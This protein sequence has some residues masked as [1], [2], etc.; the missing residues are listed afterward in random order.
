M[1][2]PIEDEDWEVPT[3]QAVEFGLGLSE[4]FLAGKA[5]R[6]AWTHATRAEAAYQELQDRK[7]KGAGQFGAE[8][9]LSSER[10]M[11]LMWSAVAGA[12]QR[13]EM[14]RAD[15]ERDAKPMPT[16][17][18]WKDLVAPVPQPEDRSGPSE[19]YNPGV[20]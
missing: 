9:R 3:P 4:A 15:A 12:S 8:D 14:L 16:V 2:A 7:A 1:S 11:A 20:Y 18:R 19:A 17:S 13:A 10:D 5:E 6:L